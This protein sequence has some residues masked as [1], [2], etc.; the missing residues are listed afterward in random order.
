MCNRN[1]AVEIL[2]KVYEKILPMFKCIDSAYLYGSYARGDYN[3]E[4][5]VDILL[6]VDLSQ[7]E[8]SDKRMAVASVSSELSLEY[9]V[10]VSVT[11]KPKVQFNRFFGSALLSECF[12]RGDKVCRLMKKLTCQKSVLNM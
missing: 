1:Q 9:G 11:I 3:N 2:K 8:I 4:S 6:I 7:E 12:E 5:D 10:T